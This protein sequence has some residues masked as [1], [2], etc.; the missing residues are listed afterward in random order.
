MNKT[1]IAFHS[2]GG[3]H[4]TDGFGA[5]Y[6]AWC[7]FKD[8]ADYIP[9]VHNEPAPNF[10]GYE[11]VYFVDFAYPLASMLEIAAKVKKVV[12]IDHHKTNIENLQDLPTLMD[13]VECVFDL[14]RSGAMMTFNYFFPEKRP[15]W[16]L[17]Y[18]QDNDLWQF[19]LDNSKAITRA[20]RTY[21]QEFDV[22]DQLM[23]YEDYAYQVMVTKGLPLEYEF[24]RNVAALVK[25]ENVGYVTLYGYNVRAVNCPVEFSSEV[26]HAL[27]KSNDTELDHWG[28]DDEYYTAFGVA[29][30]LIGDEVFISLRS[31]GDFDVSAV[32]Q[33]YGGG[34]HKNAAGCKMSLVDWQ[35]CVKQAYRGL[36]AA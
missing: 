34:G 31:V 1:A 27:A 18:I 21:E 33:L 29:Y 7:R 2:L 11:T 25:E 13:N 17:Y 10:D 20:L 30:S 22:W 12:V 16:L 9:C 6:A 14:E 19:K 8:T 36:L 4:C 32:A 24:E 23:R 5:A 26:G 28:P 35:A 15:Y 3:T